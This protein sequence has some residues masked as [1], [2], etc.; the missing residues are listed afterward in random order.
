MSISVQPMKKVRLLLRAGS[1]PGSYTF[2]SEPVPLDLIF[3]VASTGLTPFE[4][5][6]S[7]RHK[8][9]IIQMNVASGEAQQFFGSFLGP[10]RMQ[11]NISI[12][13]PQTYFEVVVNDIVDP[14][15]SEVVKAISDSLGNG[16]GC[17]GSCGC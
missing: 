12:L 5:T 4:L 6:L 2:T 9:D 8:G 15:N 16:C 11:T 17:G 13:P 3:G 14:E 10:V 7:E 1:S